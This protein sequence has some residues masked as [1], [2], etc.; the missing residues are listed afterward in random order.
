MAADGDKPNVRNIRTGNA[1][2]GVQ[3]D[4]IV[5]DVDMGGFFNGPMHRPTTP[6]QTGGGDIGSEEPEAAGA[7]QGPGIEALRAERARAAH[8]AENLR[9]QENSAY[10]S[11]GADQAA[12]HTNDPKNTTGNI[13]KAKN[14]EQAGGNWDNKYTG[15][16]QKVIGKA[17]LKRKGPA[18]VVIT[19]VT[20]GGL[21][22]AG[23]ISP[24]GAL[25][26][27]KEIIQEK[28]DTMSSVVEERSI[29][30]MRSRIFSTVDTNATCKIKVKCRYKGLTENEMKNLRESGADVLDAD[31][32]PITKSKLTGR[33]TGGKTLVVPHIDG[34]KE[35]IEAKAYSAAVRS[36]PS[37]KSAVKSVWSSAYGVLQKSKASLDWRAS[38]KLTTNPDVGDGSDKDPEQEARKKIFSMDSGEELSTDAVA[39]AQSD[40]TTDKDGKKVL[41]G[42]QVP[43]LDQFSSGLNKASDE[44]R[45]AL[46]KGDFVAPIPSDIAGAAAMDPSPIS[47][48]FFGKAFGYLNPTSII[49]GMCTT[50]KLANAAVMISRTYLLVN[51]MRYAAIFLAAADKVKAGDGNSNLVSQLMT[52]L[53][54]VDPYNDAFGDSVGYQW[55]AYGTLPDKDIASSATGNAVIHALALSVA[56]VNHTLGKKNVRTGCKILTNPV[57]QGLLSLTSFIP[58][59]GAI[60]SGLKTVLTAGAKTTIEGSIKKSI[61]KLIVKNVKD[62]L[63]KDALKS[64][65]KIA[66]KEI[67]KMAGGA[68]GI[69]VAGYFLERYFVPYMLH[70]N[71]NGSEDGVTALDTVANGR[72]ATNQGTG[73]DYG[74]QP[75]K[76]DKASAFM[77]FDQNYK[78]TY[79]ADMRAQSNPF[80]ILDPYSASNSLASTLFNFSSKLKNSN[81]LSAPA[82]ILSA[83]NPT[84]LLG[85]TAHAVPV[86][87]AGCDDEYLNDQKLATTPFCNVIVGYSNTNK[88]ENTTP[89]QNTDWM[90][91]QNQ[92]D[93]NGDPVP[94]SDYAKFQEKCGTNAGSMTIT[95]FEPAEGSETEVM[96]EVCY[97]DKTDS[98]EWQNFYLYNIDTSTGD[99]MDAKP[100]DTSSSN[101]KYIAVGNIPL[102]GKDVGA[103]VFG[104]K[105]VSGGLWAANWADN[106]GNDNGNSQ[107]SDGTKQ[108][109]CN[110]NAPHLTGTVSFAELDMGKAL[111]DIPDCTKLEIK[112]KDSGKTIIA[113]KQDIGSGGGDVNGH[114]RAVDLWWQAANALGFN[115]GTGVVTI[116]AVDPSTPETSTTTSAF[117]PTPSSKTIGSLFNNITKIGDFSIASPSAKVGVGR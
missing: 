88:L 55:A 87:D 59:G 39:P 79:E 92:I 10:A 58:G 43:D 66:G 16:K 108:S 117:R 27:V 114:K 3:A 70:L 80:D 36:N 34:S 28:F 98:D 49:V 96:P 65:G 95:D 72:D 38:K 2:V 52:I 81:I 54:R 41:N 68:L 25:I 8:G 1:K 17:F 5:G 11:A 112:F 101:V 29:L 67:L 4:H 47:S 14:S 105:Q 48:G 42:N 53:E 57:T 99:A 71:M 30:A 50:Y 78:N 100:V 32:K 74:M 9:N 21:G 107:S 56:W 63:T 13:D 31:G 46:A 20:G 113:T 37:V 62:K 93:E 84:N 76:A 69:F 64:A 19:V 7:T 26:H 104:G 110:T 103:S 89:E 115:V 51:A 22:I 35:K 91:N 77:Q 44:A 85:S 33:Y 106:G 82:A 6:L 18:G 40:Y 24:A 23:L 61:E 75:I 116:H 83:I 90:L 97:S 94:D 102:E 73:L 12:A 15:G 45:A 109:K 60:F 111:G 86:N